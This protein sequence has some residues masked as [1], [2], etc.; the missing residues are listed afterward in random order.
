MDVSPARAAEPGPV[1]AATSGEANG[2]GTVQDAAGELLDQ[3][4]AVRADVRSMHTTVESLV[5]SASTISDRLKAHDREHA[6]H[7][8]RLDHLENPP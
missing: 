1:A 7:R 4:A 2:H 6:E 3:L 5:T 8:H